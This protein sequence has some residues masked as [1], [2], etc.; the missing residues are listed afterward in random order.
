MN[1]IRIGSISHS[2][3][4]FHGHC[5]LCNK[6]VGSDGS[7]DGHIATA[8]LIEHL[9]QVH[10]QPAEAFCGKIY[11]DAIKPWAMAS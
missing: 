7:D 4:F 1:R 11:T 8:T 10:N 5:E 2:G 6:N 3:G 9:H